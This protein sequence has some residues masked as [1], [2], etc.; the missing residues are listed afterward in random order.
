MPRHGKGVEVKLRLYMEGR[1]VDNGLAAVQVSGHTGS[2]AT[3]QLEM[4]PT[5][6]I[7]HVLPGTWIH[8][9]ATDPWEM[10]PG[11]DLG[12]FK[13]LFEGVVVSRGFTR[14]DDSRAFTI[15]CA[16]PSVYWVESRQFWLN[17]AGSN[18]NIVD[19]VSV[20][21]SGGAG[22]YGTVAATGAYG[23]MVPQ[24]A[25]DKSQG[26]ERF[27]DTM[28][29]V[30]D[31]L[32]N[33]NPF[34]TNIR[35][36]FRITDRIIRGPAG[37]TEQLFQLAAL[38]DFF[39]GLAGRQSGQT[40]L[41]QVV[42]QL[43]SS[44]MHEWV[45]VPAPPYITTRIFSRDAYGNIKRTPHE[46]QVKDDRG[47][48]KVDLYEF[49]TVEE[50]V[51]AS[52]IFKPHVYTLAPPTCNVLFPN[53]YDQ[54]SYQE[55]FMNETTRLRMTPQLP[56]VLGG[57][58]GTMGLFLQRPTELEVFKSIVQDPARK[59]PGL[60]TPD[61]EFG[62]S[63]GQAATF[64]D[65]D[66]TTNE[67]RIRGIV[68]NFINL[69]PA[70]ST[71]TIGDPGKRTP[72]GSRKGGIPQYL[73]NVASYEYYKSKYMARQSSISG[74]L[75]FRPIPGF[76]LLALDDSAANMNIVAYL[77]SIVHSITANGSATTTYGIKYPRHT[78]E[79]D[80]NR[81][82]F[83]QTGEAFT[84]VLDFDLYRDEKGQYDFAT[85]FNGKNQPPVPEWFDEGYRSL[86]SLDIR[87]REWFGG[88]AGVVQRVLF[89]DASDEEIEA[90][91]KQQLEREAYLESIGVPPTTPWNEPWTGTTPTGVEGTIS[92]RDA[93]PSNLA[94]DVVRA[95]D[96]IDLHDAAMS[97]IEEY[98]TSR[99]NG[100]EFEQASQ[101]TERA[102]TRIDEA[103]K[104]IGAGPVELADAEQAKGE[105]VSFATQPAAT[106][107]IN[108]KVN[109][110]DK[111]V[112][113]T[114]EGSG[115]FGQVDGLKTATPEKT[116]TTVSAATAGDLQPD[117][118][119][120]ADFAAA[121]DRMSGAFPIFDTEPHTGA[122]ALDKE[123]RSKLANSAEQRAP[124]GRARYDGRP[125]MYD[126]EFRIWQDSRRL[127]GFSPTGEKVADAA[128]A[129]KFYTADGGQ[130]RP[131]SPEELATAAVERKALIAKRA[132]EEA[133]REETDRSKPTAD[134][135]PP[136]RQAPT[137]KGLE[138]EQR[139]A[140]PQPLSEK[141]VIELRRSIVDAYRDELARNRGFTG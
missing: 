122:A 92:P 128:T 46:V 2:P 106:R 37:K 11:G 132:E 31:D 121:A 85:V 18:G 13:L 59:A 120:G 52:T 86:Q 81:P 8:V 114:S 35:N 130:Y 55:S 29:S 51:V 9:F 44:I 41:A 109:R 43:L 5:N 48:T 111:F 40:N 49:E 7:K 30:I 38:S 118:V 33:V 23:Y 80:Y 56:T 117:A 14:N 32:G 28:I 141:Q 4:V 116:A 61:A 53:M 74:P 90:V 89:E 103:F 36:R 95:N 125:I 12:D 129:T 108:Y 22:Y 25:L 71:L 79:V 97:I 124:S 27:M 24:L 20:A 78:D 113:D 70:P 135:Q 58:K 34:Y 67:E 65:F 110:L 140:L 63:K 99:D 88:S 69:S 134:D 64:T 105:L 1:L 47:N 101:F 42:N 91:D 104:F 57:R 98:R 83:K 126:F 45:S 84:G 137:G 119:S 21:T 16:D 133:A 26:E 3:A 54:L 66:W 107:V 73:Q 77:D 139:D 136:A 50:K 17:V 19:Q 115:Y 112:G 75:N 131:A 68:Y 127:A 15:Q 102:F 87:Y 60:R 94:D 72:S 100:R 76:P 96:K 39:D 6:T 138:Q 93:L 10:N 123:T 62:D 82:R